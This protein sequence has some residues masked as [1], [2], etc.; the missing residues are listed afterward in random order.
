MEFS[1]VDC[2]IVTYDMD[3]LN[4]QLKIKNARHTRRILGV[5]AGAV[6]WLGR[7]AAD[8]GCGGST[9][10]YRPAVVRLDRPARLVGSWARDCAR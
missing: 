5:P 3:N 6:C 7:S 10:G 9:P 2:M 8:P 4:K 1:I